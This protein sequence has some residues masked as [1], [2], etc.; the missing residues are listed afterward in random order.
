MSDTS[1]SPEDLIRAYDP[2]YRALWC[3]GYATAE[4]GDARV[5]ISKGSDSSRLTAMD[6]RLIGTC[7][8]LPDID[9]PKI[10]AAISG[11][12]PKNLTSQVCANILEARISGRRF[13]EEEVAPLHPETESEYMRSS[14]LHQMHELYK[15]ST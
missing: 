9:I 3:L 13:E 5:R 11:S 10:L 2:V 4:E 1:I 7:L 6:T 8:T 15:M 14:F 12:E